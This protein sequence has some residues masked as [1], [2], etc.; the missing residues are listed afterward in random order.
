MAQF[1]PIWV[2]PLRIKESPPSGP[3]PSGVVK[4]RAPQAET[5][6][7]P[8]VVEL[9]KP[10]KLLAKLSSPAESAHTLF[11]VVY[12]SRGTLPR[13]RGEKGTNGGT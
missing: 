1:Q 12:F 7:S 6:K 3:G 10:P 5:V 13:K 2:W 8:A 4:P 11:S 9:S